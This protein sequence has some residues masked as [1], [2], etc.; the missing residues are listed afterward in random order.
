MSQTIPSETIEYERYVDGLR[1]DK[2][3]L[4]ATLE[5]VLPYLSR[6]TDTPA[7]TPS[8]Y[9]PPAEVLRR[10]AASIECRDKAIASA[11]TTFARISSGDNSPAPTKSAGGAS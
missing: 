5:S 1:R 10:E 7:A 8:M 4:L 11:R 9:L 6:S 3:D 2:A